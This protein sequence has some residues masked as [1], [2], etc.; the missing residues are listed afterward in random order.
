[1]VSE[2]GNNFVIDHVTGLSDPYCVVSVI[3]TSKPSKAKT[4]VKKETLN[5]TWQEVFN[6]FVLFRPGLLLEL[7]LFYH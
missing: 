7:I 4:K 1:M 3:P 6:L 2:G 5:P